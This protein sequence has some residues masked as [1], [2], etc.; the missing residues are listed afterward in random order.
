MILYVISF[1]G[2]LT[3]NRSKKK[4]NPAAALIWSVLA[5]RLAGEMSLALF[6][7]PVCECLLNNI[8]IDP[9]MSCK[10]FSII[11]LEKFSLTGPC[12]AKIMQT[13]I[14]RLLKE[15]AGLEMEGITDPDEISGRLQAIFCAEWSLRN[16][17]RDL[18][19]VSK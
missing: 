13:P 5:N 2:G 12:K 1:L 15:V 6:S 3:K 19:E 18:T 11:A 8:E 4:N 9:D 17:F 7:D 10:V 14:R 16:I